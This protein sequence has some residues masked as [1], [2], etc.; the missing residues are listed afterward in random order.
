MLCATVASEKKL[1]I[2]FWTAGRGD[3]PFGK[4]AAGLVGRGD[5]FELLWDSSSSR[6]SS[7]S[8]SSSSSCFYT[9]CVTSTSS[10]ESGPSQ[11]LPELA[12]SS[13]ALMSILDI[14]VDR[15]PHGSG[16]VARRLVER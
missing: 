16:S 15:V 6:S 10:S 5:V 9:T 7:S 3:G 12:S 14:G 1:T 11:L 8:S 13:T 4:P 2:V